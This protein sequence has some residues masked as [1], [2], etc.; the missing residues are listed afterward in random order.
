M[1]CSVR[2]LFAMGIACVGLMATLASVPAAAADDAVVT[3]D[4]AV[5]GGARERRQSSRE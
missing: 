4:K 1:N 5:A 3:A 2:N